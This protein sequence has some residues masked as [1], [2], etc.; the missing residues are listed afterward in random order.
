MPFITKFT[1]C[2]IYSM[3]H[4]VI[5]SLYNVLCQ[6]S[7]QQ[8]LTSGVASLAWE[9]GYAIQRWIYTSR[10][11]LYHPSSHLAIKCII[12]L[13]T[14]SP[15]ILCDAMPY[16]PSNNTSTYGSFVL[17]PKYSSC[18][19]LY[20]RMLC[21]LLSTI[22]EYIMWIIVEYTYCIYIMQNSKSEFTHLIMYYSYH[23]SINLAI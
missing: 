23:L 18:S 6:S 16:W 4:H 22:V 5:Y 7:W 3:N 21:T 15:Y 17:F 19:D 11:V 10:N 12:H 14:G 8:S 9:D 13:K 1:Q 2:A 20:F